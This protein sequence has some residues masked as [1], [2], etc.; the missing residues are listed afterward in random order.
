MQQSRDIK[1]DRSTRA[2]VSMVSSLNLILYIVLLAGLALGALLR[3][4]VAVA[5][6][7]CLFGL[8]QWG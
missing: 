6:V 7:V 8:K 5:A 3:P 2:G 4:A 1:T